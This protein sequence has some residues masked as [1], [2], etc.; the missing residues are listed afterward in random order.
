MYLPVINDMTTIRSEERKRK[1][2]REEKEEQTNGIKRRRYKTREEKKERKKKM[3]KYPTNRT[4]IRR[5]TM[6]LN[7]AGK[8]RCNAIFNRNKGN[9]DPPPCLII[10]AYF[11][12]VV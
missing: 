10:F 1:V 12:I 9:I 8:Q 11:P 3:Q 7:R 5:G 4:G 6:K 2:E